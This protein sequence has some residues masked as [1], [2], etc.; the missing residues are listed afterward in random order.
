M[1]DSVVTLEIHKMQESSWTAELLPFGTKDSGRID[2][3]GHGAGSLTLLLGAIVVSDMSLFFILA[4]YG[5]FPDVC[6]H[7]QRAPHPLYTVR[8][9]A[10][11]TG[12]QWWSTLEVQ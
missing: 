2:L 9:V 8:F 5:S 7:V 6:P 4:N 1:M 11:E 10:N 3:L 12:N